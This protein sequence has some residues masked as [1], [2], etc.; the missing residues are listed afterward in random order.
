M[1]AAG[2]LWPSILNLYILMI[3][4]VALLQSLF[5]LIYPIHTN[6]GHIPIFSKLKTSDIFSQGSPFIFSPNVVKKWEGVLLDK[7][8][9]LLL[10]GGEMV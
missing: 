4:S 3:Q 1:P 8:W 6:M 7:N 9:L 5:H 2:R 10:N